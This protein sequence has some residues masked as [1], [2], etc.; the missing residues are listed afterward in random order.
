[1]AKNKK[2]SEQ[3]EGEGNAAEQK[4]GKGK[5]ISAHKSPLTPFTFEKRG[6]EVLHREVQDRG[7]RDERDVASK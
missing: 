5:A 2:K 1:L 6:G 3:R 4:G 7:G